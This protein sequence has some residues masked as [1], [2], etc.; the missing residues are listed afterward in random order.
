MTAP[1]LLLSALA[2]RDLVE[3][4]A[5]IAQ[6]N[7]ARARSFIGELRDFLEMVALSPRIGRTR[8]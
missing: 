6:D 7:V 5:Y 8:P 1:Q 4:G 2:E 3:I